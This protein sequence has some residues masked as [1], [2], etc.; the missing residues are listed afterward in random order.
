[1]PRGG[2]IELYVVGILIADKDYT[3]QIVGSGIVGVVNLEVWINLLIGIE[4]LGKP[5]LAAPSVALVARIAL[6]DGC[7]LHIIGI[8]QEVNHRTTVIDLGIGHY[9]HTGHVADGFLLMW[10]QDAIVGVG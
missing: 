8:K 4:L 5:G 6:N 10:S 3:A 2:T 1:M 9:D 7:H